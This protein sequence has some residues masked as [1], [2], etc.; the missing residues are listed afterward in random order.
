MYFNCISISD[1]L[2][3]LDENE[4]EYQTIPPLT[5]LRI[6]ITEL[7]HESPTPPT[8]EDVFRYMEDKIPWLL[9]SESGRTF[10]VRTCPMHMFHHQTNL[11]S[12]GNLVGNLEYLSL[13]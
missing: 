12:K 9:A 8:T 1:V 10:E 11:K 3:L 6:A 5:L 13:F 7:G 2:K 4:P